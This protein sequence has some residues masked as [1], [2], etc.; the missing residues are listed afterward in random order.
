MKSLG[1]MSQE[2][3]L[4]FSLRVDS[5][6]QDVMPTTQILIAILSIFPN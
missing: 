2:I 6:L 5:F 1:G 3:A 4:A